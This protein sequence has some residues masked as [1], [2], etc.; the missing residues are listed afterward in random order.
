MRPDVWSP[1]L[2]A[3]TLAGMDANNLR[4][5]VLVCTLTPSP[6]PSSSELLARQVA[7]ELAAHGVAADVLR[8]ADQNVAPGVQTDMGPGD[9]W[10]GIRARLL[11]AQILVLATPIWV[12]HPSSLAQRVL[13]RLDAELSETDERGRPSMSDKVGLVAVVGNE[14]GAHH[15]IADLSQGLAEVGFT[16]P[17]Q[18]STYWV[19]EAM[20]GTDYQDL[21]EAPE[22]TG[23]A[24]ATAVRNTVHL[25]AL[26]QQAPYPAPPS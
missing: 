21:D 6:A 17:A 18:G 24:T 12:G 15:V 13:E 20:Q 11:Q 22:T 26:L 9:D 2:P 10:P 14:D 1:P 4:A 19:G 25:A 3:G 5:L 7:Q 16:I 23:K 8:I